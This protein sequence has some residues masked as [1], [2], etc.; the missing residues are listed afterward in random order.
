M[1]GGH[2]AGDRKLANQARTPLSALTSITAR[3]EKAGFAK[4]VDASVTLGANLTLA[5]REEEKNAAAVVQLNG[6]FLIWHMIDWFSTACCIWGAF[7][8]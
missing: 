4:L 1:W 2:R 7:K 5:R 3:Y 6:S 8:K